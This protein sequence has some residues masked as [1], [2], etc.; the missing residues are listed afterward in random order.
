MNR[1]VV[2]TSLVS[3]G[4]SLTWVVLGYVVLGVRQRIHYTEA[5]ETTKTGESLASALARFG[6]PDHL[7]P[8]HETPGYDAGERS[9]CGQSCWLR[10][11]YEIPFTFGAGSFSVDFDATEHVIDKYRWSSP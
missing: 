9:V 11:W 6:R 7:E 8:H 4:L 5:Y 1:A 2:K 3:I 10:I